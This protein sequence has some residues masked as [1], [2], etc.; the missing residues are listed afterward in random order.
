MGWLS[1][2]HCILRTNL[3]HDVPPPVTHPE[4]YDGFVGLAV[5]WQLVFVFIAR[6][7]GRYRPLMP[8]A[9]LEKFIYTVPVVLLYL[10]GQVHPKV[11]P[12]ALV[13]P[14]FG[15]LFVIAYLRTPW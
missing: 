7:P 9:I 8:I 6:D 5:L 14:V 3:D 12:L 10:Q 13:D 11:V 2:C 4:F 1:C 15:V